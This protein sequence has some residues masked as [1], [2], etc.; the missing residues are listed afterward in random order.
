MLM[1][2]GNGMTYSPILVCLVLFHVMSYPLAIIIKK[3]GG[4]IMLV[5]KIGRDSNLLTCNY[6]KDLSNQ[7]CLV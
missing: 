4:C 7:L 3:K 6:F 5:K 2:V 1:I